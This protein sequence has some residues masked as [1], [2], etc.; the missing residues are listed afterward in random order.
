MSRFE[1]IRYLERF[2]EF[3]FSPD[4]IKM[5][6]SRADR[7]AYISSRFAAK[8]AVIKAFPG[9]ISPQDFEIKKDGLMPVV[10]FKNAE[11]KEAEVL[12]SLSHS[13]GLA[14]AVAIMQ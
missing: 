6:E 7:F 4:E 14:V 8:E 2:L 9:H 11:L 10:V 1:K 13:D 5:I 3:I 12:L